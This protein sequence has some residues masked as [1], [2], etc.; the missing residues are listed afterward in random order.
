MNENKNDNEKKIKWLHFL[1]IVGGIIASMCLGWATLSTRVDY[2][3]TNAD[4]AIAKAESN[5]DRIAD[6]EKD[7][8]KI[9]GDVEN[10]E[11]LKPF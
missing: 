9:K 8:V 4:N 3:E 7:I 1:L 6:T 10:K 11:T 5:K 2:C